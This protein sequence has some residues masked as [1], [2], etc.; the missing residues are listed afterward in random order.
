MSFVVNID[1]KFVDA[2]RLSSILSLKNSAR[3]YNTSDYY[4]SGTVYI[5][6]GLEYGEY[7]S[8]SYIDLDGTLYYYIPDQDG[9]LVLYEERNAMSPEEVEANKYKPDDMFVLDF[10]SVNEEIRDVVNN[11]DGTIDVYT[12][13]S[14]DYMRDFNLG[15]EDGEDVQ[16]LA[17][18]KV[19]AETMLLLEGDDSFILDGNEKQFSSNKIVYDD[20]I[21][22]LG[23]EMLEAV[24]ESIKAKDGKCITFTAI[25][26]ADTDKEEVFTIKVGENHNVDLKAR[27]GYGIYVD[28]DK[29]QQVER[30]L[31]GGSEDVT[32]YLFPEE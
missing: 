1:W 26:D 15:Y 3:L 6:E 21:S 11:E 16:A 32:L 28:K 29:K 24:K 2:N 23:T 20:E 7:D 25:Y 31:I 27:D 10:D 8:Y 5:E 12:E 30:M 17:H 9:N 4:E 22:P 18:Y 13:C 19:D 14:P